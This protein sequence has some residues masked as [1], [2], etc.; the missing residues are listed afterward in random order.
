[1]YEA[2]YNANFMYGD[3][4]DWSCLCLEHRRSQ[5]QME[6]SASRMVTGMW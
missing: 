6:M 3:V 5:A 4:T 2:I 1:M